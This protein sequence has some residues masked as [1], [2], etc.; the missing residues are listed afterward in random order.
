MT[1]YNADKVIDMNTG[2][3]NA[4]GDDSDDDFDGYISDYEVMQVM[5]LCN[6]ADDDECNRDVD[7]LVIN[8][9]DVMEITEVNDE[10]YVSNDFYEETEIVDG[11]EIMYGDEIEISARKHISLSNVA[12][13]ISEFA[14]ESEGRKD[15]TDKRPIDFLTNLSHTG[16]IRKGLKKGIVRKV[17]LEN[18]ME[19]EIAHNHS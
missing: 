19:I 11:M 14:R 2:G 10:Y 5:G 3:G 9:N 1:R 6:R 8:D 7:E 4:S 17:N 12:Y 18:A 15:I 13:D 16:Q